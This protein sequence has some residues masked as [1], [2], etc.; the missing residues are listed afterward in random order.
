MKDYDYIITGAGASGLLLA[1]R[2]AKDSFFDDKQIL[3]IDQ[4]KDKGNDRTWSYWEEGKGEWDNLISKSWSKIYFGSPWFSKTI[5]LESYSY[6]TLQSG[7]FYKTLWKIINAKDNFSFINDEIKSFKPLDKGVLVSGVN[8]NYS[9]YKLFNSLVLNN[10]YLTQ[11]KYPVLQ[12]HFLGWFVK[13]KSNVFDDTKAT[14]MDFSVEQKQN[15]RFMYVLPF[16]KDYALFEYTLFSKDL[17]EKSEYEDVIKEYL[18]K[19][20]VEDY[21]ISEKEYGT[22]PM[23]AY[24]FKQ[25]N[26]THILN[27][28]TAGG[29]TKASTGYTF[30]N[31][32]KK[33]KE[34][35]SYLKQSSDLSKFT[36]KTKFWFYDLIFLDVLAN[37][38]KSGAKLF[39]SL[40]KK[41]NVKTIFKFLDE[42]SS[43]LQD[44]KIILAVPP[45]HFISAFF[46][47]L[48]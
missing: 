7:V 42:E 27:I 47:R 43:L 32:S 29:W 11:Q 48:F 4:L 19:E 16:A 6:K 35:I 30:N 39:S 38:N 2:M 22:I 34:V 17:L 15:T 9:A 8:G 37:H 40:F 26:S 33:T 45:K 12:Q 21:N 46:K 18:Q 44:L 24:K 28:G 36:K 14:F 41:T 25:Y 3:I 5:T 31:T 10:S 13:T 1:Y 23:T 20:G